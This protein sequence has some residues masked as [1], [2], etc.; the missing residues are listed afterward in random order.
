MYWDELQS[1]T[2]EDVISSAYLVHCHGVLL[3]K[4]FPSLL[5]GMGIACFL[6][7]VPWPAG[8]ELEVETVI[9]SQQGPDSK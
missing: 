5:C 2:W 8:G 3:L 9:H 7:M 6:P 4:G 1:I